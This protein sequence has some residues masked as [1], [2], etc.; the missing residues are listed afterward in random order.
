MRKIDIYEE[1]R[2]KGTLRVN[3]KWH[4]IVLTEEQIR[5]EIETRLPTL[6]GTDYTIA[7]H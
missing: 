5:E 7:F 2:F 3:D 1:G 6:K 4:G